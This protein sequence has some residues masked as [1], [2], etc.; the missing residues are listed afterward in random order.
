VVGGTFLLTGVAGGITGGL[1]VGL[2]YRY[3]HKDRGELELY[4]T[5]IEDKTNGKKLKEKQQKRD[6]R[7]DFENK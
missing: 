6:R 4:E 3:L 2:Y 7:L 5:Y 1:G